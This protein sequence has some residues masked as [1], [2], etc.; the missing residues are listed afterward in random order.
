MATFLVKTE[1]G[2]YSFDDLV[3]DKRTVWSGVSNP[4]ALIQLRSMRKGDEAFV[5]HTGDDKAIVG[6]AKVVSDP[7]EDPKQPGR[8][9][10][11][12]PKFAVVGLAPLKEAATA[13]TLAAIKADKRFVKFPLIAQPRLSVMAVPGELEK[14]LRQMAGV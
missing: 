5:Y 3:R 1:P 4:G 2:E 7:Y 12:E 10:R 9:E 6:L 13:V 14:V 8:N 11:G